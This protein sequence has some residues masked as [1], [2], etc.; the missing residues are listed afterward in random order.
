MEAGGELTERDY[1]QA[2]WLHLK[3]RRRYRIAGY[4][5]LALAVF[6]S[7]SVIV[8]SIAGRDP[9]MALMFFAPFLALLGVFLLQRHLF[10]RAYRS[11]PSL[12]G[13]HRYR[14][15]ADGF[16][17]QSEVGQGEI[18]WDA[19]TRWREGPTLFLLY[20]ADN[21]FHVLPKRW[22]GNGGAVE[23]FRTLLGGLSLKRVD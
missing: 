20:Q 21:L 2:Q 4:G 15:S 17:A 6:A 1:L 19:M 16:A 22:F 7:L 13:S 11:Q 5:V 8:A 14:F 3:P 23:E 12:R 10:R 9:G 18:R